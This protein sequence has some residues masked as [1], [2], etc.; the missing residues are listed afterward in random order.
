MNAFNFYFF[1]QLSFPFGVSLFIYIFFVLLLFSQFVCPYFRSL[2]SPLLP[3]LY[4][5]IIKEL[6]IASTRSI[7][8]KQEVATFGHEK[9]SVIKWI[10]KMVS[11]SIV[12]I[13]LLCYAS[14]RLMRKLLQK[15]VCICRLLYHLFR[16]K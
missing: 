13:Y 2:G 3:C 16:S 11:S 1:L 14:R 7:D 8:P 4:I 5:F 10:N 6:V 9:I 15:G 12:R